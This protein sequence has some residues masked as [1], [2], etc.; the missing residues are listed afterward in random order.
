MTRTI[1][2]QTS[3]SYYFLTID[4]ESSRAV[5]CTC[6]DRHY[7][8]HTCKHMSQFNSE[9]ER[10]I[11]FQSLKARYDCRENGDLDTRRCYFE[12]SLCA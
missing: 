3:N 4:A 8:H 6:P 10:A 12:L 5:D 11:T 2:S 7:R 1:K 9:L